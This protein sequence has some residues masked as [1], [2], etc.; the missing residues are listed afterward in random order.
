MEKLLL[1]RN[2]K[3]SDELT[4]MRLLH[5]TVERRL[6]EADEKVEELT[7]R[8]EKAESLNKTLESDL[9]K[10]QQEVEHSFSGMAGSMVG[11]FMPRPGHSWKQ[12][13][14]VSGRIS[15]TSSIISGWGGPSSESPLGDSGSYSSSNL[16]PGILPMVTAQRDRFKK[17]VSDLEA[18]VK[19]NQAKIR[20]LRSEIEGLKKDNMQLYE[21]SRY[22]SSMGSGTGSGGGGQPS[23]TVINM[24]SSATSGTADRSLDRYRR[25][26]EGHL[27][28]FAAFRNSESTRGMRRLS[29]PERIL[30]GAVKFIVRDRL[31]CNLFALYFLVVHFFL[32]SSLL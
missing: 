8:L 28:P 7:G 5:N 25:A 16:G 12:K 1:T 27:S 15:P 26:Y 11:S 30:L 17:T 3:L 23:A 14:S 13:H 6:Q 18:E 2:Q 22:L 4:D 21:K 31:A 9:L 10:M 20:D 24:P 29:L 32:F 19:A